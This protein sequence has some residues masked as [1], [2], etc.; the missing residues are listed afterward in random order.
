M[1]AWLFQANPAR[2]RVFDYIRE[3]PDELNRPWTWSCWRYRD[4]VAPGDR[5]ALW[6][7]G[8]A[9]AR[10]VY[11]IGRLTGRPFVEVEDSEYW[12][13][14]AERT[15][16]RWHVE[17]RFDHWLLEDP[18]LAVEL[19]RDPRFAGASILRTPRFAN[20]HPVTPAQ[21]GAIEDLVP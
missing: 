4:E 19:R 21:W 6:V 14:P 5:C 2:W 15:R 12:T 18:I 17:M 3:H 10:G 8:R 16:P 1:R 9:E 13:D 11:A 20:P 7:S